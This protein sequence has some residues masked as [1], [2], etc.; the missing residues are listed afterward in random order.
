MQ[1]SLTASSRDQN[2]DGFGFGL[3]ATLPDDSWAVLL[4]RV[5][6]AIILVTQP[7]FIV[8]ELRLGNVREVDPWLLTAFHL[9]NFAA[10]LAGIGISWTSGFRKHW[11]AAAFT[12]C[13]MLIL[14]ST[15]MS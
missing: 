9:F 5:G 10:A 12:L 15:V 14:S 8:S 3:K 1:S 11:R 13:A 7:L 2:P 4:T 6:I